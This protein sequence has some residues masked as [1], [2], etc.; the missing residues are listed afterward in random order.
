[1]HILDQDLSAHLRA[2]RHRHRGAVI[3]L[4]GL[5][6]AGTST[7]RRPRAGELPGFTGVSAPYEPPLDPDLEL[8]TE[9]LSI[10][11]AVQ[12]LVTYIEERVGIVPAGAAGA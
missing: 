10:G 4:T 6:R 1:M 11:E 12:R 5:P 2:R 8:D 9:R 3:W 7:Y